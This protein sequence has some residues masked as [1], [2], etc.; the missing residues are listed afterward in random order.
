MS[1]QE[2]NHFLLP[3]FFQN[4]ERLN[5]SP[6]AQTRSLNHIRSS[7]STLMHTLLQLQ[8]PKQNSISLFNSLLTSSSVNITVFWS[9]NQEPLQLVSLQE[10]LNTSIHKYIC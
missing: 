6:F 8:S 4:S 2:E 1:R 10:P 7:P 3:I 5:Y 9:V